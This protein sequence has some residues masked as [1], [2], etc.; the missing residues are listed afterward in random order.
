MACPTPSGTPSTAQPAATSTSTPGIPPSTADPTSGLRDLNQ[1]GRLRAARADD[2]S[3]A[4]HELHSVGITAP[5]GVILGDAGYWTA[6]R[7]TSSRAAA[8]SS[9][10]H[11]TAPDAEARG[12]ARKPAVSRSLLHR[13]ATVR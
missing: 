2:H 1:L 12:P 5:P 7:W 10:S 4:E 11:R 13:Q 9:W 6:S 3:A 8:S